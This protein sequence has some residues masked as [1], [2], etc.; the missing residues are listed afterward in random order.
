MSSNSNIPPP[1]FAGT[2]YPFTSN[3]QGYFDFGTPSSSV[4][5]PCP[6]Q[7]SPQISQTRCPPKMVAA[8]AP[9]PN[10]LECTA[11][12]HVMRAAP[13]QP[14]ADPYHRQSSRLQFNTR[15]MNRHSEPRPVPM[16]ASSLSSSLPN[17]FATQLL[18]GS[19]PPTTQAQG[20]AIGERRPSAPMLGSTLPTNGKANNAAFG[21]GRE[22]NDFENHLMAF[23]QMG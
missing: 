1:S 23:R 2:P 14:Q 12:S 7:Q 10:L 20:G 16:P 3:S 19:P 4:P 13:F 5:R 11:A 8:L 9:S 15:L 17:A 22:A 6:R 18:S 21:I